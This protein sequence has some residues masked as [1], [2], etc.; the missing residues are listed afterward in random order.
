MFDVVS[1]SD[2]AAYVRRKA[3]ETTLLTYG[4][5]T[6]W[7]PLN[8]GSDTRRA[9]RDFWE[10]FAR[11]RRIPLRTSGC[12][13]VVGGHHHTGRGRRYIRR[14]ISGGISLEWVHWRAAKRLVRVKRAQWIIQ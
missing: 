10:E 13:I 7:I 6:F 12:T 3:Y 8:G 11:A 2:G 14:A 9:S 1:G 5:A 4:C